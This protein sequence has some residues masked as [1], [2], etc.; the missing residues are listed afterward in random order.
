MRTSGPVWYAGVDGCRGGWL[1]ILLG[2]R[3][4]VVETVRFRL[5][6]HF[7]EIPALP[8]QPVR[9]AVDMP[10]GLP[11]TAEAGGR[12][13]DRAARLLL[14]RRRSSVFSPP[15]RPAL[16]TASYAEAVLLQRRA[17][18]SGP[19]LTRQAW[20]IGPRIREVDQCMSPALQ[21]RIV[22]SHPE[23]VF[24]S[25][26]GEPMAHPKRSAAG[27]EERLRLLIPRLG[28]DLPDPEALRARYGKAQ[29]AV[30]DV[31]DACALAIAAER[32]HLGLARRLPDTPVCDAKGLR[33]EIWY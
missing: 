13:C 5:V 6:R 3:G 12:A 10:I 24:L 19:G 33:M 26:A 8:E 30:D 32:I 18:P 29:L 23:L 7:S 21:A 1:V 17:S 28:A 15:A 16:A 2:C 9:V 27:R 25:L 31:I 4:A 14:G 22:E 20:N 11:E